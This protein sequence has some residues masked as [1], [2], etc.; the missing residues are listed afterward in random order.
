MGLWSL[1]RMAVQV[2]D[3]ETK[4]HHAI[5]DMYELEDAEAVTSLHIANHTGLYLWQVRDAMKSLENQSIIGYGE[6]GVVLRCDN[7]GYYP[8]TRAE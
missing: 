8:L 6:G 5:I 1:E 4:V 2:N 7:Q 3:L